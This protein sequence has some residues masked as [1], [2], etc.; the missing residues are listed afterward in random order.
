MRLLYFVLAC[1]AIAARLASAQTPGTGLV[2]GTVRSAAGE[3]LA[4]VAVMATSPAL[5]G[6]RAVATDGNGVYLL[7]ALLPGRY[8]V[9][10]TADGLA[11]ASRDVTV[12]AATT[13]RLDLVLEVSPVAESVVV[14]AAA[15][16]TPGT[17]GVSATAGKVL[18]DQLPMSRRPIDIAELAPGLTTNTFQAGQAAIGGSFGY[19]NVFL[20][21]G[22]DVNDN[23]FGTANTLFIEDAIEETSVLLHGAPAAFGRFSGGVINVV[24]KSGGNMFSGSF[25][26]NLTNPSWVGETPRQRAASIENPNVLGYTHEATF[27]GPIRRDHLWFFT[28]G[29]FERTETLNTFPQTAGAFTRKDQNRRGEV[30]FT[31]RLRSADMV[32]LSFI[33]DGTEQANTAAVGATRLLDAGALITRRL[34]NRLFVAGYNAPLSSRVFASVQ[35][36]TKRQRFENNGGSGTA[37]TDSPFQ[38]LG[39]TVPG[40]F[41][42]NAPYLDATD[43]ESRNNQQLTGTISTLLPTSRAGS[44]DVRVGGEYFVATGI[45]GN[46]QSPTGRVYVTDYLTQGGR[47]VLDANSRVVPVFTPG[48]SQVW[49]YVATRG[50]KLNLRTGS[51]YAQDR[52]IVAPRLTVDAGARVEFVRG[53]T[54]TDLISVDTTTVSPRLGTAFDVTGDGE[55]V[56][57]A[58]FGTY[59]GKY[60]QVQFSQNTPVG[61]PS[62]VDYVYSGPAGQGADFAPGL[63]PANY[64]QVVFANFPTANVSMAD[65]LRSP[66]VREFTVGGSRLLPGGIRMRA[67][68]VQRST[69]NFIDDF[70]SLANGTTNIPLVGTVTNRVID[71]T[72]E[73]SREYRAVILQG[74]GRIGSRVTIAGHYTAQIRNHGSFAGEA[75]GV[76][77]A[78][79]PFGDFP[80]I[81]GPA[82]DRLMPYGRLDQFQRHKLRIW[83]VWTAGM[84]RVGNLEVAPLWRVNSGTAY[85][86]TANIA[87]PAAQR[88][89]NP[90][91]PANDINP[92]VR[93]IVFFGARGAETFKGYGVLDLA[94]TW[95]V[96]VWRSARPWIKVEVYN[97]LNNQKVIAWDRTVTADATSALD[98][99]GIRTGY[100]RGPRFG[101][102]TADTH[103]PQPYPG[104]NGARAF[105][106][107][108]GVRF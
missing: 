78:P 25:R 93:E 40:G 2:T 53:R 95:T 99:N 6:E 20:V 58:S 44:H 94:T 98:A 81:F 62:E 16:G 12:N 28:A 73:P 5:P 38:T 13:V 17:S 85:S 30:K 23:I 50:A 47:P 41:F 75:A 103:Y 100:V 88:A 37:L 102:A 21:N 106:M 56:L 71:N 45:G 105:R 104:Q 107:A 31:G 1:T 64:T 49:T 39:A 76:P 22:V 84:G 86:L 8:R 91:Y 48:V 29:R 3:P 10:F 92:G 96:P 83:G 19:D 90:G 77:G 101:Q 26:E 14:A 80:E 52:W 63:D 70:A 69:S 15:P 79:S 4:G 36:S 59:A 97:L 42:Y 87:L 51:L 9:A 46:S 18:V 24:T 65:D 61:R 68:W 57:D 35:W 74:Q 108:F 43:P 7:R 72:D 55:T 11:P 32:Q 33:G 54:S 66:V 67:T 60:T 82:L 27:G 34:P 89:R